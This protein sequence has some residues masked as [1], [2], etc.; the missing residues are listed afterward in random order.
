MKAEARGENGG[1]LIVT[2]R[3]LRWAREAV[4]AA[5][6]DGAW[7]A[8][9]WG[10]KGFSCEF[11]EFDF[12]AGGA[13]RLVMRGP[14]GTAYEMEQQFLEIARPERIVV[15]H[16]QAGHDFTLTLEF[17]DEA[18]GTRVTWRMRFDDAA[19]AERVRPIVE[20][21]NEEN[22]DR[23]EAELARG[24]TAGGNGRG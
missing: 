1:G 2:T 4:F 24:G 16:V 17:A 9:W 10:P 19:E 21:A 3:R 11:R 7:V 18:G 14:D 23:L 8:R 12:R 20:P 13:W 5:C 6:A 15:R 22:L